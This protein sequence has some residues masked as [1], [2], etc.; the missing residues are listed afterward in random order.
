[1]TFSGYAVVYYLGRYRIAPTV[2]SC[3]LDRFT[4]IV[5]RHG[6]RVVSATPV[7]YR[8]TTG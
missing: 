1:M 8:E 4:R 7:R 6:G 3:A 5:E 2:A